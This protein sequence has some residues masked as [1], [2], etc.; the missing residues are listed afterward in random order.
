MWHEQQQGNRGSYELTQVARSCL[1]QGPGSD[2]PCKSRD[3]QASMG[4]EDGA[5]T[6]LG[7]LTLRTAASMSQGSELIFTV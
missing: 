7:A 4:E 5:D 6:L 2:R 1:Q 3:H